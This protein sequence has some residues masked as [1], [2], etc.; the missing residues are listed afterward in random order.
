MLRKFDKI[1]ENNSQWSL[2]GRSRISMVWVPPLEFDPYCEGKWLPLQDEFTP[3][4]NSKKKILQKL[5]TNFK[6]LKNQIF[7]ETA[8][9]ILMSK[10]YVIEST[11]EVLKKIQEPIPFTRRG[12]KKLLKFLNDFFK[13]NY[14]LNTYRFFLYHAHMQSYNIYFFWKLSERYFIVKKN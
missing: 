7:S 9:P 14:F 4:I 8:Q 6:K 1:G 5:Q 10:I 2:K 12:W 13:M 3:S 11:K